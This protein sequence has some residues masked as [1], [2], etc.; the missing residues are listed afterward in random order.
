[1]FHADV[2]G[3]RIIY[4]PDI[5]MVERKVQPPGGHMA[6]DR[7]APVAPPLWM[8]EEQGRADAGMLFSELH[9]LGPN[10]PLHREHPSLTDPVVHSPPANRPLLEVHILPPQIQDA[11]QPKPVFMS[12]SRAR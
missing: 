9:Q 3:K 10:L 8:E 6:S 11:A 1:M 12:D 2:L 4:L 7:P 5:P